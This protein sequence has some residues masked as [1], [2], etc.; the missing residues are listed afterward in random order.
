M[1]STRSSGSDGG[2]GAGDPGLEAEDSSEASQLRG[3]GERREAWEA[4]AGGVWI[5]GITGAGSARITSND[6]GF[7]RV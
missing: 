2:R 6:C 4:I 7:G 3:L 1:M 5:R